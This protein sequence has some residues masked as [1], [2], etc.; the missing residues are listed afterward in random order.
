MVGEY[1]QT[2]LNYYVFVLT[3]CD[4]QDCA[5]I[6]QEDSQKKAAGIATLPVIIAQCDAMISLVDDT[7]YERAWCAVETSMMQELIRSYK[8]HKWYEYR[9]PSPDTEHLTEILQ[10]GDENRELNASK[11]QLSF[12]SDRSQLE[13]LVRQSKLLG[14]SKSHQ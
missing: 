7:Y 3:F 4:V 14:K 13:F 9:V 1:G 11:L 12:E 5:C 10:K 6:D 8:L 2:D